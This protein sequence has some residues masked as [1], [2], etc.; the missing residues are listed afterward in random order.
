[1]NFRTL[2]IV[3]TMM[4]LIF[5][6]GCSQRVA[7][8]TVASTQNINMN[9][10]DFIEG[11]RVKGTDTVAAIIFPL[12]TP[13][14]EEAFDDAIKHDPCIVGLTDTVITHNW[15][16]LYFGYFQYNVE[17]T[18]LIDQSKVGCDSYQ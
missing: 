8:L 1:M 3:I 2:T 17:G 16:Y 10:N 13:N 4:T 11:K 6:T 15:F 12:G 18:E 14:V 9:S 7:D 5:T